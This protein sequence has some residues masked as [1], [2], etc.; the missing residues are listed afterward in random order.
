MELW[1]ANSFY[2]AMK[3]GLNKRFS[4]GFQ[5]QLS[6]N[7]SKFIDWRRNKI[8]HCPYALRCLRHCDFNICTFQ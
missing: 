7:N 2:N 6:Y 8:C 1:D 5:L 4:S 3:I